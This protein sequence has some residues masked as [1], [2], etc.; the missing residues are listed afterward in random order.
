MESSEENA[1][2][3]HGAVQLPQF[4]TLP[5]ELK[6]MI[7][8]E[9]TSEM[10]YEETPLDLLNWRV[11]TGTSPSVQSLLLA[12]RQM[13]LLVRRCLPPATKISIGQL[14]Q[15]FFLDLATATLVIPGMRLPLP[16]G[17][18]VEK[19]GDPPTSTPKLPFKKLISVWDKHATSTLFPFAGETVFAPFQPWI[20]NDR[21]PILKEAT[22]L[23]NVGMRFY[24]DIEDF[25][26][27]NMSQDNVDGY[28][29]GSTPTGI[30]LGFRY[31]KNTGHV[32]FT[33]L[34]LKDVE[35]EFR[36]VANSG[37]WSQFF[38]PLMMRI[39][40]MDDGEIPPDEPHHKWTDL[41]N[42]GPND[43]LWVSNVCRLWKLAYE[44]L[45]G[46]RYDSACFDGP[47]SFITI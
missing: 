42:P 33:P 15:N 30:W 46:D 47:Q 41:R 44:S 11:M 21:L 29:L 35:F 27:E 3:P 4:S 45:L 18:N 19:N 28:A 24:F 10:T 34:I 26:S 37:K 9:V 12:N 1:S 7:I 39:W 13:N 40:I 17:K 22:F 16:L 8:R 32:Q 6:I 23:T 38:F 43:P 36:V 25:V 31:F 2:G 5:T 14:S 20:G